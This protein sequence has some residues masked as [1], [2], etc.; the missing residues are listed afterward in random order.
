MLLIG[1]I[2]FTLFS[3]LVGVS[4]STGSLVVFRA[5]QG[6]SAAIMSPSALSIVLATFDEGHERN[7]ALGYWS[8]VATGG[9]AVG[10]LLGGVLTQYAGW[11][12]NFFINVPIGIV[13]SFVILKTVPA[14]GREEER[15]S[16]DVPGALLVTI[17]LMAAVFYFSEAPTWG[18][19]SAG[20]I[21]ALCAAIALLGLF[22][23]NERRV[24]HPLMTLAIFKI[25][26]L[27]GANAMMALVYA[28]NLGM[29]FLL[30]LYLQEVEHYSAIET[31]LAFLPFP[32]ILG[33][34]SSQIRRLIVLHGYRRYLILGPSLV[35]VGMT[36]LCFLPLQGNYV[37]H[38]LP[39]FVL[40]PIGYGMSFAP[41][42]AAATTGVPAQQSG[43]ASGLISTSQQM[44]GAVGLA[45]LSG[46]AAS[47]TASLIHDSAKQALI[48]GYN[49]AMAVAVGFT[50][51]AVLVAVFVIRAPQ[52]VNPET[53]GE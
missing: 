43:L 41:M 13:M 11:R 8:M 19:L 42:Y 5:L 26:N 36:W 18:W 3:F 44:G 28:G 34:V 49:L 1:M 37:E 25:R 10:L 2:S 9:A 46:I 21:G 31:G 7:Q 52:Q 17:G 15:T 35:V 38:V 47:F 32:I 45:I 40:M 12:W 23:V 6:V 24:A 50:V 30:T 20:T 53:S 51:L 22:L 14:H 39:S 33:T 27:S 16:L 4:P 48:S 29:F